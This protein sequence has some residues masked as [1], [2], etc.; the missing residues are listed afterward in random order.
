MDLKVNLPEGWFNKPPAGV[1]TEAELFTWTKNELEKVR[2]GLPQA[3]T[4]LHDAKKSYCFVVQLLIEEK[5]ATAVLIRQEGKYDEV[6]RKQALE[7]HK[8][9]TVALA[10]MPWDVDGEFIL[11]DKDLSETLC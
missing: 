11:E 1:S 5:D 8:W 7:T 4:C 6:K 3:W 2:E 10:T 9:V